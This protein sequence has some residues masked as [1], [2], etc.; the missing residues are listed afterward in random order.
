MGRLILASASPRRAELL[1]M[2]GVDFKSYPV[3]LDERPRQEEDS[4]ALVMR[5]ARSKADACFRKNPGAV[6]LA[7]DTVVSYEGEPRGKPRDYEDY[8]M[9]MKELSGTAHDVVSGV[10]VRSEDRRKV[11][12]CVTTVVFGDFSPAWIEAHWAS[13]E[14]EDKAGGYAIQGLAGSRVR[15]IR[16]SYTNVVGLPLHETCAILSE[17]GISQN[18]GKAMSR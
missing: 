12:N 7:A 13:G 4:V 11:L 10:C 2:A 18:L 1:R 17:F 14:P 3:S 9:M 16:G 15:E 6:V 5:L 8:V